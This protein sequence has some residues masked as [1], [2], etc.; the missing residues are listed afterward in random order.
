MCD[1]CLAVENLQT[2]ASPFL[3]PKRNQD[4]CTWA[5]TCRAGDAGEDPWP[6]DFVAVRLVDLLVSTGTNK[7]KNSGSRLKFAP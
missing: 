5:N 2:A 6:V 3:V 4:G 7:R 1:A